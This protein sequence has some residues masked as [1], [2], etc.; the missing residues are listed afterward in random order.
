[1]AYLLTRTSF[2]FFSV[3][4]ICCACPQYALLFFTPPRLY[5]FLESIAHHTAPQTHSPAGE[6]WL[7]F[8]GIDTLGTVYLNEKPPSR[9]P[10][11]PGSLTKCFRYMPRTLPDP[12]LPN[13]KE[14][15]GLTL[16]ECEQA[17]IADLLASGFSTKAGGGAYPGKCWLYHNVTKTSGGAGF[18]DGDY[19]QKIGGPHAHAPVGCTP[20]APP[21]PAATGWRVQ[22]QF[23]RYAFPVSKY[24]NRQSRNTL[25]VQL[26][27]VAYTGPGGSVTTLSA[28]RVLPPLSRS[29]AISLS[30]YLAISRS[31]S[32]PL[33]A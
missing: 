1:M 17:A 21:A 5:A 9:A 15:Q 13:F 16:S 14:L 11:A 27:S 26:D 28:L 7:V 30:R 22:D 33:P 3:G 20:P 12:R 24:L 2:L 25:T 31:L 19:Y 23:L 10:P 18:D 6:V 29:L 4:G 8:D 32:L